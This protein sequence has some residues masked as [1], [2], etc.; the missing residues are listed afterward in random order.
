[1]SV[2]TTTTTTTADNSQKN[3]TTLPLNQ[4]TYEVIR[5]PDDLPD[6]TPKGTGY[7]EGAVLKISLWFL[8]LLAH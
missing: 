5:Q 3:T 6:T 1:M 8:W 2:T 7:K 4:V